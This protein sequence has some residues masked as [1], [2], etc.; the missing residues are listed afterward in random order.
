MASSVEQN[1]ELIEILP[2][3]AQRIYHLLSIEKRLHAK[4]IKEITNYSTRTVQVSLRRLKTM[5]LI[6]RIPDIT[7]MRRSIYSLPE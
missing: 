1:L 4:D 6:V 3:A 7:D 5:D 2:P